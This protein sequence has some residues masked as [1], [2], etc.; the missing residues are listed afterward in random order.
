MKKIKS[1]EGI[2]TIGCLIVFLVHFRIS[3]L[4]AESWW[5]MEVTPLKILTNDNSVRSL[6]ILSG[7][8]LSYKY[9]TSGRYERVS[10]DILKRYFRLV[11]PVAVANVIVCFLMK[12]GLLYNTQ[13]AALTGSAD[14]GAYNC[15]EPQLLPCLK[16][17]F[18]TCFFYGSHEYIG[19]LWSIMYEYLG[20]VLVLGAIAVCRENRRMRYFFYVVFLTVFSSVYNYLVL[21]MMVCDIYTMGGEHTLNRLLQRHKVFN[22]LFFL[23]G[24]GIVCMCSV[25]NEVKMTRILFAIGACAM[26]LGL[27]NARWPEKVLG[28]KVMCMGGKL[29]F[30]I[31]IVHW[32]I[33]ESFSC[34]YYFWMGRLGIDRYVS[35]ASCLAL[36]M[37]LIVL[38]AYLIYRYVE[39]IGR[40]A[41]RR[42]SEKIL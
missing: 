24:L 20:A 31:Y 42:I 11:P 14:L 35:V 12:F 21:G 6:L 2:R 18:I 30:S 23:A 19:P 22:T 25:D 13:V 34:A 16:E 4:S 28:N 33:I 5:L 26:F 1:L 27:L 3:F 32:P 29:S 9:F 7:F 37:L 17:A 15:F 40:I 38:V 39:E 41:V 8:V 10:G 36:T